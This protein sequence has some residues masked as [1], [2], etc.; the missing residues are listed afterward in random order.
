M[1]T[2]G[3]EGGEQR[4]ELTM[5]IFEYQCQKCHGT[6]ESLRFS[7]DKDSDV[8]CPHCGG[9]EVQRLLSAFSA[10]ASSSGGG[11]CSGGS[12]RFS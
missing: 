8:E 2:E 11:S 3:K 1:I 7:S 9:H 10:N 4:K 12:S 6:F 5:P